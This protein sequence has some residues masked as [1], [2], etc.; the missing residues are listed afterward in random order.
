MGGRAFRARLRASLGPPVGAFSTRPLGRVRVRVSALF[1]RPSSE[2]FFRGFRVCAKPLF[3]SVRGIS[4]ITVFR[5]LSRSAFGGLFRPWSRLLFEAFAECISEP[6]TARF[7]GAIR[8]GRRGFEPSGDRRR[9]V[10]PD[11]PCEE[12]VAPD[13]TCRPVNA[14]SDRTFRS[15]LP[16]AFGA[17]WKAPPRWVSSDGAP[18][19][20]DS[21]PI[22]LPKRMA[23]VLDTFAIRFGGETNTQTNWIRLL[24]EWR[25]F[26]FRL[27]EKRTPKRIGYVFPNA[28]DSFGLSFWRRVFARNECH[29]FRIRLPFVLG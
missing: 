8:K 25:S 26:G 28:W 10:R 21:C 7:S 22:R 15:P 4:S 13:D 12:G 16:L 18:S 5:G 17:P 6:F 3:S 19:G 20:V 27:V 1:G 29:T 2:G 11:E 24:N 9:Q 14:L 23:F